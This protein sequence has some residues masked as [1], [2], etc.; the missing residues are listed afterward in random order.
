MEGQQT[1]AG[2][3]LNSSMHANK[4]LSKG[5]HR[6]STNKKMEESGKVLKKERGGQLFLEY[7]G[8]IGHATSTRILGKELLLT[9]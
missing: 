3:L 5:L 7:D 1:A 2:Y 8:S 9:E 4:E 6:Q